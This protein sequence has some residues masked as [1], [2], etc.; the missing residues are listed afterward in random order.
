MMK[1]S[2]LEVRTAFS[3]AINIIVDSFPEAIKEVGDFLKTV[4]APKQPVETD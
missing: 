4:L 1:S 2:D 3:M